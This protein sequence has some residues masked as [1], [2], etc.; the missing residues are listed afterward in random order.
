MSTKM[1]KTSR[2]LPCLNFSNRLF[3]SAFSYKNPAE[4]IFLLVL[5]EQRNL[6]LSLRIHFEFETSAEKTHF[7]VKN[8]KNIKNSTEP[9]YSPRL[10]ARGEEG[11]GCEVALRRLGARRR[12]HSK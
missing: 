2:I 8:D 12:G 1:I 3:Q 11:G 7:V 9:S 10:G 6:L 4:S 5:E